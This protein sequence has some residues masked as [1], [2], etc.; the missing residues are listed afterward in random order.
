[1]AFGA[2]LTDISN[3]NSKLAGAIVVLLC[4]TLIYA[5]LIYGGVDSGAITLFSLSTTLMLILWMTDTWKLKEVRFY[6]SG[7]YLPIIGLILIGF[8]QLLPLRDVSQLTEVL[9]TQSSSALSLD[10]Y[11]TRFFI[12]RLTFYLVFFAAALT[13]INTE[14]NL[15]RV[16]WVIIIFG[17]VMAFFGIL[18]WLAKPEAIYGLRSTP[19][20][21]PFGPFVNQHHFAALMEMTGGLTLGVLLGKGIK[22]D[23]KP[24]LIIAVI[25]MT[26]AVI[27]TGSRGGLLSSAGVAVFVVLVTF[28]FRSKEEIRNRRTKKDWISR[29]LLAATGVSSAALIAFGIVVFLGGE[30]SFLRGAGMQ[31]GQGDF[32]SGR[33]GFWTV[34]LQIFLSHPIIGA[35]FDAFGVAFTK[36]DPSNGLFRVEQAH[37]DYL[38][39]LADGGITA[40]VC[41]AAFIYFLFRQGLNKLKGS[42]SRLERSITIGALAGCFGILIHSFLDFPLRTPA[43]AFFFLMVATLA[44]VRI[45]NGRET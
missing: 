37:N 41:I 30:K 15:R 16:A 44:T 21:I 13:F 17:A 39:I 8:I 25:L 24:L 2:G 28:G 42:T 19:Q 38:Q 23:R 27:L 10:P 33:A 5:T 11:G 34:A 40:F 36:S 9:G 22:K 6:S 12:I 14:K 29:W 18:Q 43:N 32:T 35:G 31:S 1:L 26:I 20:A 3:K 4:F 45:E 7:L